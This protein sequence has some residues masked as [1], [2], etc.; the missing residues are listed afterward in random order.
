MNDCAYLV[1]LV[2]FGIIGGIVYNYKYYLG[3]N[4]QKKELIGRKIDG[5]ITKIVSGGRKLPTEIYV[6]DDVSGGFLTYR[7]FIDGFLDGKNLVIG[8]KF[9]KDANSRGLCFHKILSNG[10][11]K[12]YRYNVPH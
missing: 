10:T 2:I 8:D 5:K 4:K 12:V 6:A 11:T 3:Y 7:L 1:P 9:T